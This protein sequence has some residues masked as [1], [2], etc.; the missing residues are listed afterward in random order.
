M[1]ACLKH[2]HA[3]GLEK[4]RN[5]A[6]D[7][8]VDGLFN[9]PEVKWGKGI[10]R[11]VR[12]HIQRAMLHSGWSDEFN[13]SNGY[14]LKVMG[15]KDGTILQLQTGNISRVPYDLLNFQYLFIEKR[16]DLI[17]YCMP[18]AKAAQASGRS[19]NLA[20][21]ERIASELRLFKDIIAVPMLLVGFE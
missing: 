3:G 9:L 18:T 16:T 5:Q 8:W 12:A 7:A 4:S 2:S 13:V 15:Q 14:D 10:G 17:I 6:L 21:V 19:S 11:I 1:R 20:Q